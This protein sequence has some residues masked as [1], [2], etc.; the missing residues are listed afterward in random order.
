MTEV[1]RLLGMIRSRNVIKDIAQQ[2]KRRM[3]C[4]DSRL[5]E[6]MRAFGLV[7]LVD[8][9]QRELTTSWVLTDAGQTKY[10]ELNLG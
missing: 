7:R 5:A 9:K 10:E 6:R 3:P 1:N 8:P 4:G 2:N